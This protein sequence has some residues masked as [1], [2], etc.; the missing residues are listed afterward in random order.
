MNITF[1]GLEWAHDL[2]CLTDVP[3]ILKVTDVNTGDYANIELI[4]SGNLAATTDGEWYITIF[5][6]TITNVTD[7]KNAVNKNFYISSNPFATA[8]YVARALNNCPL[9]TANFNITVSIGTPSVHIIAKEIGSMLEGTNLTLLDTNIS[10]DDMMTHAWDGDS[11][12]SLYGALVDVKINSRGDYVTTLE[13]NFYNGEVAFDLSPVLTTIAEVG[14]TIPFDLTLAYYKN[15]NYVNMSY[16][17]TVTACV[18]VGYMCNQG[19]KYIPLENGFKIAQNVSRGAVSGVYNNTKLYLY[20]PTI[21]LSFYAYYETSATIAITYRN[22]AL[23]VIASTTVSWTNDDP[24]QN[25]SQYLKHVDIPLSQSYLNQAFYVDVTIGGKTLRYDVIKPL[26]AT[27]Y[28]QRIYWRNSY[29]GVSFFDFTGQKSETRELDLMTYQK[30][31]YNY[32]DSPKNELEKI[33]DN[34]VKYTVTLKSHLFEEDGKYT[35][36]DLLQSS[37]VWTVVNGEKYGIILDA[38]S[39]EEQTQ[40]NVYE[41][42]VKYHYSMHPSI[43]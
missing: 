17:A 33:Y 8:A 25:E 15:G 35:F 23:N 42:T 26:K 12:S 19:L 41:A 4:F 2:V 9:L 7:Y 24:E 37:D 10:S 32:Y 5:G 39:V 21:P 38:V 36:N 34:D 3:N 28:C 20:E 6:E 11:D 29:G 40:N 22:S 1:N 16:G 14:K 18:A 27:E 31:I 30:S 43:I 13:K